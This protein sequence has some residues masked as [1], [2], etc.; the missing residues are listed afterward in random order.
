MLLAPDALLV[1]VD[2]SLHRGVVAQSQRQTLGVVGTRAVHR[3]RL[4]AVHVVVVVVHKRLVV[5]FLYCRIALIA[6]G[7]LSPRSSVVHR[8]SVLLLI[9]VGLFAVVE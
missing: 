5:P 9:G 4:V 6:V 3:G 8:I 2:H 1:A 7:R